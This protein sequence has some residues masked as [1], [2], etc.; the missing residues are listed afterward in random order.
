MQ[1]KGTWILWHRAGPGS[2][3]IAG[4]IVIEK[5][6]QYN[7]G[8]KRGK[9]MF[10]GPASSFGATIKFANKLSALKLSKYDKEDIN[11]GKALLLCAKSG[12]EYKEDGTIIR[13][14]SNGKER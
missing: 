8:M 13:I 3:L 12:L 4:S 11:N 2:S 10:I 6:H 7:K 5:E 9:Y 14:N 1:Q